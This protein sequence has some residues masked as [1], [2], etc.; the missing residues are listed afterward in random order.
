MEEVIGLVEAGGGAPIDSAER[1]I[2]SETEVVSSST[3][4]DQ[5]ADDENR[6]QADSSHHWSHITLRSL[7]TNEY[8]RTE[9]SAM[10]SIFSA[11]RGKG[12]PGS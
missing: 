9:P 7:K 3:P 5:L 2:G 10:P 8:R 4:T 6:H 12:M 1:A 11:C